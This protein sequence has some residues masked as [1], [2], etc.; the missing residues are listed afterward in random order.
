MNDRFKIKLYI[1]KFRLKIFNIQEL[2][3]FIVD[4]VSFWG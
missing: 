2:I 3:H 1:G 4:L